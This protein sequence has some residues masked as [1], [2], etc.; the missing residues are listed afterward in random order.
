MARRVFQPPIIPSARESEA[1]D[2]WAGLALGCLALTLLLCGVSHITGIDTLAGSGASEYQLMKAFSSGGLRY[3]D[4]MAPPDPS[5]LNDPA[6][7]AAAFERLQ[8]RNR[9]FP[10]ITYRVDTGATTPCPT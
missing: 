1:R 5:V 10:K 4:A 7:S 9:P 3:S 8:Q 6:L 2:A